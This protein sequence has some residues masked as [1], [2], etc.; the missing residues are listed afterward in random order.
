MGKT[1]AKQYYSK[2]KDRK[3]NMGV[4]MHGDGS[5]AGQGVVY[6][7]FHLSDLPNYTTG[8]MIHVVVNNQVSTFLELGFGF[9][10]SMS[11]NFLVV[12]CRNHAHSLRLRC[13]RFTLGRA[14][15]IPCGTATDE[16]Q[17]ENRYEPSLSRGTSAEGQATP[18]GSI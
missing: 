17:A 6:E 18:F 10:A 9:K 2:D 8:G 4:L 12:G 1:R 15:L 5:F 3:K 16:K 11:S 13:V 7:T 14:L